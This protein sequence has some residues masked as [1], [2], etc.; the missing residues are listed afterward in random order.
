MMTQCFPL[1][2]LHNPPNLEGVK[3]CEAIFPG[4]PQVGVFDTA[5]HATMPP[6]AYLYGLPYELYERHGLR[7]YG[8][9]GT[10]HRYVCRRAAAFLGR[11]LEELKIVSCHLGNG[12]S[13]A[14]VAGGRSVDTSMGL[15]PLEGVFMGTRCGDLDPGVLLFLWD[16][17]GWTVP[18]WTACSTRRAA[19]WAWPGGQLDL[20][21]SRPTPPGG[22]RG[23]A[24]PW[25]LRLPH[26]QVRGGLC[27]AMGG[28]DALVFTA[29]IGE[30]SDRV[31][32]LVCRDLEFLG[33]ELDPARNQPATRERSLQAAGGRW[34]P[35]GAHQ[36]GAGDRPGDPRLM[37]SAPGWAPR[38]FPPGTGPPEPPDPRRGLRA[39]RPGGG[40][41]GWLAAGARGGPDS[42]RGVRLGGW[43]IGPRPRARGAGLGRG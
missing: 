40:R 23:P 13:L 11:P 31:R 18:G 16:R 6:V 17:G 4:L 19:S 34:R 32:S 43:A 21:T 9:H 10:S 28:L 30:N 5:F 37:P 41:R 8:F 24:W 39:R 38:R 14:A 42:L 1:A 22:T 33:I 7:R 26:P 25:S 2:P 15:T 29:G 35:G 36:R 12:S 27:R 3:A 20:R